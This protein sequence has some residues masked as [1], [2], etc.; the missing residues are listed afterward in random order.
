[1]SNYK[2]QLVSTICCGAIDAN[3]YLTD[4]F[5]AASRRIQESSNNDYSICL[6]A[7]NEQGES[8]VFHASS[9]T[10]TE[11]TVMFEEPLCAKLPVE[12]SCSASCDPDALKEILDQTVTA[13][14][15]SRN[16]TVYIYKEDSAK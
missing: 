10:N 12:I 6:K 15:S 13:A 4:L 9:A 7:E 2:C 1:M 16:L 14:S 8:A 3:D 11:S 5:S